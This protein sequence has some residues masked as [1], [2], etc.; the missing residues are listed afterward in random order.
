MT[1]RQI[2]LLHEAELRRRV[3]DREQGFIDMNLAFAGGKEAGRHLKELQ[4][5]LK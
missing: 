4:D 3:Q 5:L 2:L 1:E